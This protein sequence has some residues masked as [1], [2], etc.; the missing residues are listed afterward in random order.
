MSSRGERGRCVFS[1]GNNCNTGGNRSGDSRQI[2]SRE[3]EPPLV[4][5]RCR[6]VQSTGSLCPGTSHSGM[7]ERH[8]CR[9]G[10]WM[11]IVQTE[12][13]WLITWY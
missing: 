4:Q 2:P 12:S 13:G 10:L 1:G 6:P 5:G 9:D 3:P 7:T 11:V 8:V